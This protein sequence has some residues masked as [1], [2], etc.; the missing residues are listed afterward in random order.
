MSTAMGVLLVG[1]PCSGWTPLLIV[2][3][4]LELGWLQAEKDSLCDPQQ[5]LNDFGLASKR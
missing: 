4:D 5:R 3:M 2:K 1:D